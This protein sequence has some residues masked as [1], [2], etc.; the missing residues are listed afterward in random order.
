M[1]ICNTSFIYNEVTCCGRTRTYIYDFDFMSCF[2]QFK[3]HNIIYSTFLSTRH[4]LQTNTQINQRSLSTDSIFVQTKPDLESKTYIFLI[5]CTLQHHLI[6]N[7][8][9]DIFLYVLYIVYMSVYDVLCKYKLMLIGLC[10]L[11]C[12]I[13]KIWV[14]NFITTEKISV[15]TNHKS[16][17]CNVS[18]S[19]SVSC[20]CHLGV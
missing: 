20:L 18:V 11:F 9:M 7:F 17:S 4:K 8:L 10:V 19:A 1:Y 15:F 2:N 14:R 6:S 5:C 12:Y 3:L 16:Q 13:R